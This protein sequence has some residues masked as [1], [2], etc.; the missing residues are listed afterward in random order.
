MKA[1]FFSME[2]FE[3]V[4]TLVVRLEASQVDFQTALSKTQELVSLEILDLPLPVRN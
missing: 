4:I 3:S 1:D 2:A